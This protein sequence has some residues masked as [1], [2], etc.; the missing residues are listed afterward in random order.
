MK[1]AGLHANKTYLE[2]VV[3]VGERVVFGVVLLEVALYLARHEV[4][5]L[6]HEKIQERND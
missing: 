4:E 1:S 2:G 3:G 5:Q 6:A